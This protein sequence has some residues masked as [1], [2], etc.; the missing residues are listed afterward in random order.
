MVVLLAVADCSIEDKSVNVP[1]QLPAGHGWGA[2]AAA[3][4]T[5]M[6]S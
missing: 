1:N 6:Y 3:S 2:T 5:T 4:E